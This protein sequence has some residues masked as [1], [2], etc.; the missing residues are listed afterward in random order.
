MFCVNVV[1]R[2]GF[3]LIVNSGVNRIYRKKNMNI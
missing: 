1:E 2:N 3:F